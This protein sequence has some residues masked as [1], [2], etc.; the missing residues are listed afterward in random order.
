MHRGWKVKSRGGI[1]LP[2]Q[3]WRAEARLKKMKRKKKNSKK[4]EADRGRE[5]ST[6]AR[7]S[8]GAGAAAGAGGCCP[9]A[10]RLSWIRFSV[11][12]NT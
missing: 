12:S 7:Y 2:R 1:S 4:T 11:Q 10:P 3:L 9:S 5:T 8:A 6:V